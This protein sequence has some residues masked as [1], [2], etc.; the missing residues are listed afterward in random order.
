MTA[1]TLRAVRALV[2][3][4]EPLARKPKAMR[5]DD[6]AFVLSETGRNAVDWAQELDF[7]PKSQVASAAAVRA[8]FPEH[9]AAIIDVATAR[10]KAA[11]KIRDSAQWVLTTEAVEQATPWPVAQRRAQRLAG[12]NVHDLTCSVGAELA[13]LVRECKVVS[14]SDIDPARVKMARANV[15]E[16]EA[17]EA[18][19]LDPASIRAANG[20]VLIADPARRAGGRRI[21]NP[22]DLMPPLPD[23]L[24]AIDGHDYAIK[25]AP[26]LDFEA[27][28]H[29]GE[30][31][32]TSLD[33][34]VREA[35]LW[36][37]GLSDGVRRRA[38]IIH[39]GRT[40]GAP[41]TETVTDQDLE[42]AE[43][44][45]NPDAS[46]DRFI[47]EPDGAI[48]RAGLVR[49]WAHRHGLRQLDPRIAHLTG[50]EIP[51]GYSG[52]EVLERCALDV[53]KLKARL[54]DYDCGSLEILVRGVD[55]DPDQLRKKLAPK[56]TRPLTLVLTRLGTRGVVFI[57]DVRR[58]KPV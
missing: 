44:T 14:G 19:A 35:C 46:A 6:V 51:A 15:P 21:T 10:K 32:I 11:P 48:V 1:A 25:C 26:G 42:A 53:K 52:F 41:W 45:A 29:G 17:R 4:A 20:A 43:V 38:T 3:T 33:G 54:R 23:L 18:D 37:P 40:T 34:G 58:H 27:V 50:P 22:A 12:R 24:V 39:S 56:G 36:S 31:E 2:G 49:H 30:V 28:E 8:K 55:K 13:E 47:I 7:S 16:A 5:N 57:C 9:A